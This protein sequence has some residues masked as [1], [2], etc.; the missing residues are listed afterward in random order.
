MSNAKALADLGHFVTVATTNKY[1]ESI[2]P[3]PYFSDHL[4]V[5]R[6]SC[7]PPEKFAL[8][9]RLARYL[10]NEIPQCDIVIIH[11]LYLFHTLAA[12]LMCIWFRIPYVLQPHGA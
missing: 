9:P 8:S 12:S 4:T 2:N 7:L 3:K 11:G 5:K 1:G 6:F 10:W